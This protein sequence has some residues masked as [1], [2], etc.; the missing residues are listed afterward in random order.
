MNETLVKK[1]LDTYNMSFAEFAEHTGIPQG[2]LEGWHKRKL[3]QIGEVTL[4]AFL[5][6]KELEEKNRD[7]DN[8]LAILKK[9]T[10]V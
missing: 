4:S 7:F 10:K 1:V 3:S 8:L 6:I 2:T 9:H 5:K